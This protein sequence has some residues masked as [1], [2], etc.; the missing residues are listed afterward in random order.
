MSEVVLVIM[1]DTELQDALVDWLLSFQDDIVFMSEVVNCY[2]VDRRSM[3]LADQVTGYQPKLTF[4]VQ[5]PLV[6]AQAI[7]QGLGAAFAN[8]RLR[9]WITP[10]LQT[11]YLEANQLREG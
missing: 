6:R 10:V 8:T 7:C 1:A 11:G 4:Q 9:Y 2:G 3:R 5:V